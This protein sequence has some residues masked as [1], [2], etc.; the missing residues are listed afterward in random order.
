M[1]E[2]PVKLPAPAESSSH[3]VQIRGANMPTV[4]HPWRNYR[5]EATNI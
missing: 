1:L 2:V 4:Q 3:T 5:G